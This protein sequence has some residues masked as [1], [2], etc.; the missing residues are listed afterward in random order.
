MARPRKSGERD[1]VEAAKQTFWASGFEGTAISDLERSTG[2]YRSSLYHSF[3]TKRGLFAAAIQSYV[4]DFVDPRLRPMERDTPG[5]GAIEAYFSGVASYLRADTDSAARGCLIVNTIGELGAHRD[6]AGD[7]A[8]RFPNRIRR[9]FA[10]CLK[11]AAD[12]GELRPDVVE[13]RASMLSV[14]T[15]GIWLLARIDPRAAA[16]RCDEIRD[17]VASWRSDSSPRSKHRRRTS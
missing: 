10:R 6:E 1:V 11:S 17:E 8:S 9:A 2:L 13:R 7:T 15:L 16:R 4:S 3:E 5:L 12:S 14:A